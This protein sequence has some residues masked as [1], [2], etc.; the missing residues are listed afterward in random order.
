M[1][2]THLIPFI[3][4]RARELGAISVHWEPRYITLHF[5]EAMPKQSG[6]VLELGSNQR[7]Y[8]PIADICSGPSASWA[9]PV[10][11]N[12]LYWDIYSET[13]HMVLYVGAGLSPTPSTVIESFNTEHEGNV[14][15]DFKFIDPSVGR[16]ISIYTIVAT[17]NLD[18]EPCSST[19]EC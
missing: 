12:N 18:S 2:H 6:Y 3:E 14:Y 15:F 7:L 17:Y 19:L 11:N 8:I 13:A 10:G 16:F 9:S 5:N 4:Q 1:V